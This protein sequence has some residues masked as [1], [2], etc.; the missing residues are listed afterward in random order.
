MRRT[1]AILCLLSAALTARARTVDDVLDLLRRAETRVQ[2]LRFDYTQTTKITITHETVRARGT[3]LFERPNRFRL[4]QKTPQP[5]TVV[6]D[7]ETLWFYL[8]ARGQVLRD[9]VDNWA[10]SAGFPQGLSPFR[11]DSADLREKYDAALENDD[12]KTP[13]IRLTP[14]AAA[15]PYRLRV[16]VDAATGLPVK[17]ELASDSVSAVTEVKN[18]KTDFTPGRDA[19]RFSPPAGTDVID[20]PLTPNE[21]KP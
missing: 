11:L 5:Q 14:K 7:G 16:W 21:G 12:P 13:V 10:R 17:T 20:L 1:L 6:S 2:R 8:P 3:A 19:F 15:A 18:V 9:G 4:E